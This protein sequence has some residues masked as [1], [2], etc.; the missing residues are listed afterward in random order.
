MKSALGNYRY[1]IIL[2][3][4]PSRNSIVDE[5]ISRREFLR[6]AILGDTVLATPPS[7]LVSYAKSVFAEPI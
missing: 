1:Q 3:L 6:R 7:L 4:M 2:S 5:N